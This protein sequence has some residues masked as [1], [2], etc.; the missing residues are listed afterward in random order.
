MQKLR[1]RLGQRLA[2][3][4]LVLLLIEFLDELVFGIREASMPLIR[5]SLGLDYFQLGLLTTVPAIIASF[6]EPFL[7]LLG[8]AGQRRK[9]ILGGGVLFALMLLGIAFAD[10]YALVLLA[11]IIIFP[12]SGAF[13]SLSQAS[14]MDYEP[15]RHEQNM[16]RWTLFGSLGV[17][18][19]PIALS[20]FLGL[21]FE[22]RWLYVVLAL[23]SLVLLLG[24]WRYLPKDEPHKSEEA[25]SWRKTL[26]AAYEALKQP[27]VLRWVVL[28]EFG[29]LMMDVL[30]AYLALYFVD[31]AK[32]SAIEAGI[33]ISVW[34]GVGLLGDFALV[35]ILDRIDSLRYLRL[36]AVLQALLFTAFLLIGDFSIKLILLGILGFFNAGWYSILQG[37]LYSELPNQSG[38]ALA[39]NNLGGLLGSL[40]P[41]LI[42]YLAGVW[43]LD[44]AM[45]F[46]LAG[47]LVLILGIPTIKKTEG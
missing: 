8:D 37:R 42:G 18:A 27:K 38:L 22:W 36:S 23:L 30:L 19:G 10:N 44:I 14:L 41:A 16:A 47:P 2:V 15:E 3:F 9:L 20:A 25:F 33:A 39:A 4:V 1:A 40:F 21:G 6:I 43:G 17:V 29:N 26:I 5:D 46:F 31:V 34:T 24:A 13:V 11:F 12:A 35:F 28:L 7:G 32:L 45:W